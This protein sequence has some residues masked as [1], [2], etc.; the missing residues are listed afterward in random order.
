LLS[1]TVAA[2]KPHSIGIAHKRKK[3]YLTK[4][5][6][7]IIE[8]EEVALTNQKIQNKVNSVIRKA[9]RLYKEDA[10]LLCDKELNYSAV[11]TFKVVY[12]QKGLVSYHLESDIYYKGILHDFHS[13]N[14]L[15]FNAE[16]GEQIIL[17][18]VIDHAQLS[19][20]YNLVIAKIAGETELD[21][22]DSLDVKGQL[23]HQNFLITNGGIKILYLFQSYP[24][25]VTLTFEELKSYANKNGLL[26]RL[27]DARIGIKM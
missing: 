2:Q 24:M 19:N 1:S 25:D 3:Y 14:T 22:L 23:E 12:A 26:Q 15:N 11:R 13:F 9:V 4:T 18:S 21:G 27:A 10:S 17:D 16:T 6:Y 20:L 8:W 7:D 5:C